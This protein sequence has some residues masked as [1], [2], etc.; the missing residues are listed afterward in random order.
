MTFFRGALEKIG[1]GIL[2]GIGFGISVGAIYYFVSDRM[3]DSMWGNKGLEKVI[4]TKHERVKRNESVIVLGT[5]E[6]QGTDPVRVLT[7]QVDLFDKTG[8]F[9]D[10]CQDYVQ[11]ALHGGESRNFRVSCGDKDK[12]VIEHESYKI[13]LGSM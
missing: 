2:Y 3:M 8:K 9:V 12:P 1:A 13:R 6:N 5:I 4:V 10:Q 11:G 7:I